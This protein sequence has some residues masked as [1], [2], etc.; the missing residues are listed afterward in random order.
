MKSNH[1]K[2]NVAATSK[3]LKRISII[4]EI[5][6]PVEG[7]EHVIPKIIMNYVVSNASWYPLYDIRVD[8]VQNTL[9]LLY[10]A[11]VN[12]CTGVSVSHRECINDNEHAQ[13]FCIFVIKYC[14]TWFG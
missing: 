2:S 12:Q 1:S 6:P 11:N 9:K 14:I 4:C 10:L 5:E 13:F 3:T 8:T 7:N